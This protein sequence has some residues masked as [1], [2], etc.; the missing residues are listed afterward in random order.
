MWFH[1]RRGLT[2]AVVL[3]HLCKVLGEKLRCA[4]VGL[5]G[6]GG[7]EMFAAGAGEGMIDIGIGNGW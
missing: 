3:Q 1:R 4:G 6:A 7:V 5:C 2:T